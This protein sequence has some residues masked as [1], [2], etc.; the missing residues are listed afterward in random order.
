[1]W[2]ARHHGGVEL[3]PCGH[4]AAAGDRL[5]CRHLTRDVEIE[6]V[7]LFTGRGVDYNLCCVGCER[8]GGELIVACE[9]C[10]ARIEEDGDCLGFRGTPE[11]RH[12][13]SP[14]TAHLRGMRL[15]R[16]PLDLA[17]IPSRPYAW[18]LLTGHRLI[19]WRSDTGAIAGQG[20]LISLPRVVGKGYF[21][22][23]PVRPRLH[24]SPSGRYC[25]IV[26]DF[27]Q[28]GVV[29]DRQ[30]GRL[31]ATLD[32]GRYYP[33]T[34]RFPFAFIDHPDGERFV[35]PTSWN[36]LDVS[37]AR[38]GALLTTRELGERRLDYFH[39]ALQV[40]P[41]GRWIA[42]DG[43]VWHPVGY[44]LVWDLHAWQRNPFE[45]EDGPSRRRIADRPDWNRPVCWIGGHLVL[46]GIGDSND[47]HLMPGARIFDPRTGH[48]IATFA[49]P[50]GELFTAAGRLLAAAA[51]GL[52]IWDVTTGELT[53]QVPG[54]VPQ[55]QHPATRELVALD[56]DTATAWK[57]DDSPHA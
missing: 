26:N 27:D 42:D 2:W 21:A 43:W 33:G 19:E 1:M 18:L 11:I 23:L 24:V 41:D 35:H 45:P 36:R 57:P 40:S 50:T 55:R 6:H 49:G 5:V 17:P 32:R 56:G 16:A 13:L 37:D 3:L 52:E 48:E 22:D 46:S 51:N 9:G 25:G 12:R 38:S 34:T 30:T 15:P 54:F 53:G 29:V 14:V 20:T 44:P 10:V 28:L 39:G 31:V 8:S 47:N 7:R 4:L